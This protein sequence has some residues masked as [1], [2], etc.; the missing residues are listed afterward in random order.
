VSNPERTIDQT[1]ERQGGGVNGVLMLLLALATL[2]VAIFTF[3]RGVSA[4]EGFLILGGIG[5][6]LLAC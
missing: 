3:L 1:G 2:A 4:R 6:A 5:T